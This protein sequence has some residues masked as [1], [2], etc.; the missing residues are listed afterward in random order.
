MALATGLSQSLPFPVY[1]F[2][3]MSEKYHLGVV[4]VLSNQGGEKR[5]L[6]EPVA[7]QRRLDLP[8]ES[9][10]A[11]P[12]SLMAKERTGQSVSQRPFCCAQQLWRLL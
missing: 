11:R 10:V 12:F 5:S 1:H 6:R 3:G 9:L 4:T 7:E 2:H 8:V